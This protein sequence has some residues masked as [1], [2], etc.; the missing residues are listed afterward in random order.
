MQNTTTVI[1]SEQRLKSYSILYPTIKRKVEE[2]KKNIKVAIQGSSNRYIAFSF[3]KDSTVLSHL[4]NSV[5]KTKNIFFCSDESDYMYEYFERE[6]EFMYRSTISNHKWDMQDYLDNKYK[7]VDSYSELMKDNWY[8]LYFVGLR[9]E[10]SNARRITISMTA[11]TNMIH[12]YTTW[13]KRSNPI[14]FWTEKEIWIYIAYHKLKFLDVYKTQ[15]R[16]AFSF[17][18]RTNIEQQV[19]YIR[20]KRP[21]KFQEMIVK[22]PFLSKYK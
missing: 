12:T 9:A 13:K 19:Q 15:S 11:K 16:T 20:N 4:V 18:N 5:E 2:T 14:W 3:W 1:P 10:E 7:I 21:E 17:S 22:Y 6:V 8:D